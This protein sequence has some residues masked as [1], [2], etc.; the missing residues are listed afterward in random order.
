MDNELV[1][2]GALLQHIFLYFSVPGRVPLGR[3]A[4]GSEGF[5][6]PPGQAQRDLRTAA[7]RALEEGDPQEAKVIAEEL[8]AQSTR[9]WRSM[10]ADTE[11][12]TN[13]EKDKKVYRKKCYEW[14]LAVD[15]M[16][17]TL[18][19]RGIEAFRVPKLSLSMPLHQYPCL[20]LVMDQGVDGWASAWFLAFHMNINCVIVGDPNHRQWN[21][22]QLA[23]KDSHCW[24]VLQLLL[25]VMGFDH[26]PWKDA[27]WLQASREMA[28]T[29]CAVMD[30]EEDPLFGQLLPR[31]AG[32][33]GET[34]EL[35]DPA[36][37][38]QT[39]QS[40]PEVFNKK[41]EKVGNSRWFG[42]IKALQDC[43]LPDWHRRLCIYLILCVSEGLFIQG[44]QTKVLE[45]RL[46]H[47]K[48]DEDMPK[49]PVSEEAEQVRRIRNSCRNTL[50]LVATLLSDRE[51]HRLAMV[52]ALIAGPTKLSHG[53]TNTEMR[54]S[55]ECFAWF[56]KL[57]AGANMCTMNTIVAILHDSSALECAGI[58]DM[59]SLDPSSLDPRHPVLVADSKPDKSAAAF[60]LALIG[61]RIKSSAWHERGY[62]GKFPLLA[63]EG[64]DAC[65]V[66]QEM[67]LTWEAFAKAKTLH[68]PFWNKLNKMCILETFAVRREFQLAE[69]A[70]WTWTPELA[71]AACTPFRGVLVTKA[72]EDEAKIWR[73]A[74]KQNAHRQV[75]DARK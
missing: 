50:Q 37:A 65:A 73:D 44:S 39:F 51:I 26:G 3:Q 59:E 12:A 22:A 5:D 21:D 52:I 40:L 24:S 41:W 4:L 70:G 19:G 69:A 55:S 33:L 18:T 66:L 64:P 46:Q 10:G 63:E 34:S 53:I 13:G 7:Q 71:S 2:S 48:P 56:S 60:A 14:L 8:L 1:E 68:P 16:L 42:S 17:L 20:T 38:R 58:G 31:M 11:D 67:K 36:Y 23:M 61:R 28:S 47:S 35:A 57:A 74:E 30:Y 15:H 27:R 45:A 49:V 54:S 6:L 32:D 72:I 75:S 43:L 25:V 9:W 29:Y 62:P